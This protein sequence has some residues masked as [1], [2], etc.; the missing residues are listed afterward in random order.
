MMIT[1]S[2]TLTI[3]MYVLTVPLQ[4]FT[5]HLYIL[6][7]N[8]AHTLQTSHNNAHNNHNIAHIDN[9]NI[10]HIDNIACN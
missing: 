8:Y 9:C 7:R 2:H 4:T 1:V 3:R 10:A 6:N 5:N